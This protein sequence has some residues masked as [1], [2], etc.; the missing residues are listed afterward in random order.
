ML[1]SVTSAIPSMLKINPLG[2]FKPANSPQPSV[3]ELMPVPTTV[4]IYA[5]WV[6]MRRIVFPCISQRNKVPTESKT[7]ASG[8]FVNALVPYP[9]TV[10]AVP[11]P[12]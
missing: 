6:L 9:S 4:V 7:I 8:P 3:Y 10:A 12:I 1:P 11:V 2:K 5:V